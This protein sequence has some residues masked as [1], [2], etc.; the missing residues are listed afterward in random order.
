MK[1][2]KE[3]LE[4]ALC[5]LMDGMRPHEI[6]EMTGLPDE[7][8]EKIWSV[9]E[10]TLPK[11]S[12]PL[13]PVDQMRNPGNALPK[14]IKPLLAAILLNCNSTMASHHVSALQEIM[15]NLSKNDLIKIVRG[16]HD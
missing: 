11:N 10:E 3:D 2:T 16:E 12:L 8:C 7:D 6:R 5:S 15:G 14:Q 9:Y 13:V 1:P 4:W